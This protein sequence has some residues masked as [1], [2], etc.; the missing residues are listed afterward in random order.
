MIPKSVIELVRVGSKIPLLSLNGGLWTCVYGKINVGQPSEPHAMHATAKKV[1]N[2]A[3]HAG[4]RVANSQT[5]NPHD[6]IKICPKDVDGAQGSVKICLNE[7]AQRLN[8]EVKPL[9][10]ASCR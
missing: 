7:E 6:H 5:K 3:V 1:K 2:A 8:F 10:W 9:A 4:S